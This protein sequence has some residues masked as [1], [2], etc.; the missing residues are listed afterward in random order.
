MAVFRPQRNITATPTI[1]EMPGK[2]FI[3]G[4]AHDATTLAPLF[5]QS[6][7]L[8]Y[9]QQQPATNTNGLYSLSNRFWLS[10]GGGANN[11][12]S[13]GASDYSLLDGGQGKLSFAYQLANVPNTLAIGPDSYGNTQT[14]FFNT[15]SLTTGMIGTGSPVNPTYDN[16]MAFA[17]YENA[18]TV[19]HLSHAQI[20]VTYGS[21]IYCPRIISTNTSTGVSA[22][23]FA[24]NTMLTLLPTVG[25]SASS[26]YFYG[27][28]VAGLGLGSTHVFYTFDKATGTVTSRGSSLRPT[29]AGGPAYFPS[30]SISTGTNTRA[31][32]NAEI[33]S[34]TGS[35]LN[36]AVCTYDVTTP[37]TAPI[38]T[39]V[40][41]TG[42]TG[43]LGT[44][45]QSVNLT[46]RTWTFNVGS[47]TYI[48]VGSMDQSSNN[49]SGLA[50]TAYVLHVYKCA[51][52]TPTVISYVS[53]ILLNQTSHP[54]AIVP[55]DSTFA[56][57]VM[58]T[59]NSLDFYSWSQATEAYVKSSSVTMAPK[60]ISIDQTGRIWVN[61]DNTNRNANLNVFS[62]TISS[63]V[64][65]TFDT[66]VLS[67]AGTV[68]N[69]NLIVNAYSF[70]GARI[71][72]NVTII[73][74]SN[75][76]TFADGSTTKTVSTLSTG[77]L[78]VPIKVTGAG[79]VR[80][81]ANLS[82]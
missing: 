32:F 49:S 73:L 82:I 67:Y 24:T 62:P 81:L 3:E 71:V 18:T 39:T 8:F 70:A 34:T 28:N 16:A 11:L 50:A 74:D 55:T 13:A 58:P 15:A 5:N 12:K 1:F 59:G 45:T 9:G 2:I 38:W 43:M 17:F 65:V 57:L 22:S 66:P 40:T 25:D 7:P 29:T 79:Y 35:Q 48:C 80:V 72:N 23:I 69:A 77:D 19:F 10:I 54:Q 63:T 36:F 6:L 60:A 27:I 56:N 51:T 20:G 42:A 61:E 47:N 33:I 4:Q 41:P 64:T 31:L 37:A 75:N 46:M 26:V 30:Y 21:G 76:C 78:L 53:S 52:A 68:L 44:L 14:K